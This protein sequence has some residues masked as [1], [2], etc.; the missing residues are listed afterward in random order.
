MS[1]EPI[2]RKMEFIIEQ[3]AAFSVG[4]DRLKEKMDDFQEKM[5]QLR[6]SQATTERTV[7]TLSELS[8]SLFKQSADLGKYIAQVDLQ[9]NRI[10]HRTD[11]HEEELETQ[12]VL[13]KQL[14]A[15]YAELRERIDA[16]ERNK[17][18]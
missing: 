7:N 17:S 12:T 16:I 4:L 14:N 3:Q 11:L 13:L 15:G 1:N 18:K 2:E 5:D 10:S 6:E 8:V 9:V